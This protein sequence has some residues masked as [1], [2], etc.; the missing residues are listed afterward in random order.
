MSTGIMTVPKAQHLARVGR[1][2]DLTDRE[3]SFDA[4]DSERH[5]LGDQD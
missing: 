1:A 2:R 4:L 3:K 5:A